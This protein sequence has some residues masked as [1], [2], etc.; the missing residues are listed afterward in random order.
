MY[1]LESFGTWFFKCKKIPG[2]YAKEQEEFIMKREYVYAG[3]SVVCFGTVATVSK[4]LM[5]QLDAVYVLA[6]SFLAATL[7]LGIWNWKKGY[8][9]DLRGVTIQTLIRMIVIGSLGVFFYNYFLLL[10]TNLL[11]AQ[12]AFVINEL[13]PALIIIFS[14]WILGEKM[15]LGKAAAVFFSFLGILVVTTDGRLTDFSFGDPKG[16]LYALLAAICYGLYCTLNKRETYDKNLSVM[17]SYGAGTV[18][19]FVVIILQGKM[20]V[21]TGTQTVGMLWNGIICNAL[22]YLTWAL[23]LDIGNTAVIA[24]LAYLTPFVS[25]LFTHFVLG[26]KITV[27]S[28]LGLLLIVFGIVIQMLVH[29]LQNN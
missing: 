21:P 19:A 27:F 26:E 7:F 1:F 3:T 18:I 14:C 11:E 2:V 22:P 17:I 5:N 15:N 23:A 12:T 16:I 6:F 25:L 9:K 24:N 20:A 4:L 28:V 29:R 10:G 13:W 8:L